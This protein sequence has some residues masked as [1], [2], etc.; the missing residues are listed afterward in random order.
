[1]LIHLIPR[2]FAWLLM[3]SVLSPACLSCAAASALMAAAPLGDTLPANLVNT[4]QK[5]HGSGIAVRYR[6]NG[7]AVTGQ[8]VTITLIF[9]AVRDDSAAVRFTADKELQLSGPVDA[10]SLPRG[11]SQRELQVT[12]RSDGVFYV[13]V[14]TTQAG[15]TSVVSVPIQ[16]GH[17]PPKLRKPG[18]LQPAGNGERIISMP[19]P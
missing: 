2:R 12:P 8:A 3:I 14:F 4:V 13:N 11:L 5:P 10:P 9:D 18:Q 16:S 17:V 1:M 7:T 15:A 19:V 6:V